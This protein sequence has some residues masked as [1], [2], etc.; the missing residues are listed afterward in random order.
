MNKNPVLTYKLNGEVV[1]LYGLM[2]TF[3]KSVPKNIERYKGL[4]EMD[5]PRLEES[6][7]SPKNRTL[8][9]YTIEDFKKELD[10]IKYYESNKYELIAHAKLT[11]FDIINQVEYIFIL[12]LNFNF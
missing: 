2:N 3:D 5:G 4:G 12:Y 8:I 10:Q 6:T 9:Q 7:V 1:S 11:R